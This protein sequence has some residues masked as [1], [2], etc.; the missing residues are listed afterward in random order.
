MLIPK[1][2][3]YLGFGKCGH[4]KRAEAINN[5]CPLHIKN[6]NYE[7]L[8]FVLKIHFSMHPVSFHFHPVCSLHFSFSFGHHLLSGFL[9]L[10]KLFRCKYSRSEE[11]TSELQSRENLV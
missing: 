3:I 9:P 11:H 5:L 8:W 2:A 4:K 10:S 6:Q 7:L 1:V